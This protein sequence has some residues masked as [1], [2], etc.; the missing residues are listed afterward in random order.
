MQ[1]HGKGFAAKRFFP[2]E[3][4]WH[5][6]FFC[7]IKCSMQFQKKAKERSQEVSFETGWHDILNLNKVLH[8]TV[9]F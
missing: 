5:G 9:Q 3:S 2:G 8:S 6:N 1:S 4:G 7:P